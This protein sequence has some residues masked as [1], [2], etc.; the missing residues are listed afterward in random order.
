MQRTGRQRGGA[1]VEAA[2]LSIWVLFTFIGV[3]DVGFYVYAA[4]ATQSAA[5]AAAMATSADPT[6]GAA[7][8]QL[9]ACAAAKTELDRVPNYTAFPSAC[10]AM[11]LTVTQTMKAKSACPDYDTANPAAG[12]ACSQ[13]A[14]TYQTIQLFPI[15][16]VLP[17]KITLTRIASMRFNA[18]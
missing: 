15:P 10:D 14:V 13:V 9:L 5:R 2:L 16:G 7:Q 17:G 12:E 1:I 4:I 11:P 18:P 6:L 8:Y 3:L